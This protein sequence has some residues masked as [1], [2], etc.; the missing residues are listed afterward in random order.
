MRIAVP[1]LGT[2]RSL[3]SSF[4]HSASSSSTSEYVYAGEVGE[5]GVEARKVGGVVDAAL[6]RL[7]GRRF[8]ASLQLGGSSN[9]DAVRTLE[10]EGLEPDEGVDVE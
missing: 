9:G 4:S 7:R 6:D 8:K 3:S 10:P 5:V 1:Q 2:S